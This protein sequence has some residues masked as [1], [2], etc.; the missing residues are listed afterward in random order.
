MS[1]THWNDSGQ[2]EGVRNRDSKGHNG[3]EVRPT[4]PILPTEKK[5]NKNAKIRAVLY[6]AFSMAV[7]FAGHEFARAPTNSM[8]TSDVL[9]FKSAAALPLAVG[10][11]SPFSFLLLWVFARMLRKLGPHSALM[12]STI[13]FSIFMLIIGLALRQIQGG[14]A[15]SQEND[16][17]KGGW[18]LLSKSLLFLLFIYQSS[19]VQFLYTQVTLQMF[20]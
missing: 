9:G 13:G 1:K 6:M 3:K 15:D 19:N 18:R 12:R 20:E 4:M 5:I 14:K 10:F 17:S 2:K 8:F 11:V 16:N 7:H